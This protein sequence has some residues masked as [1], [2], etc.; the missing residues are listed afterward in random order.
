[1]GQFAEQLVLCLISDPPNLM[2]SVQSTRICHLG[3]PYLLSHL[4]DQHLTQLWY[5]AGASSSHDAS[6]PRSPENKNKIKR[7][8]GRQKTSGCK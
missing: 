2:L 7:V 5:Q 3:L 4:Q 8:A 1:M 6:W